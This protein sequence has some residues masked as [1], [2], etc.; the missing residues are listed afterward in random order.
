MVKGNDVFHITSVAT[1]EILQAPVAPGEPLTLGGTAGIWTIDPPPDP[2][3]VVISTIHDEQANL[4]AGVDQAVP[5]E[6][7]IAVADPYQFNIAPTPAGSYVIFPIGPD[8]FW[9]SNSTINPDIELIS[10][11]EI[12]GNE[13]FFNITLVYY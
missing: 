7:I 4:Y 5:G 10:G 11:Y 13:A 9:A 8:L 3:R 12:R 2:Y 6:K 1:N